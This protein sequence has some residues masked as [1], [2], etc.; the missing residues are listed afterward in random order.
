MT[1]SNRL[2]VVVVVLECYLMLCVQIASANPFDKYYF[3]SVPEYYAGYDSQCGYEPKC[4]GDQSCPNVAMFSEYEKEAFIKA[5]AELL[6]NDERAQNGNYRIGESEFDFEL[7]QTKAIKSGEDLDVRRTLTTDKFLKTLAKKLSK[8]ELRNLLD[9]K[10]CAN[11]TLSCCNGHEQISCDPY[12]PYRSY[13]GSCNNLEHP[14]WGK[15]GSALKHPF[16]PCYSD[17]VSKPARS[18]SGAPLPQNRKLMVELA[19]FLNNRN[20]KTSSSLSMFM[21]FFMEAISSDMIGR[22]N[23]R[24]HCPTQGFRGCRADGQDRSAFVSTL[25]NPLRVSPNDPYY[26]PLGVRCLNFSP[27]EKAND[28]CELKHVAERNMES[29]Y[30]DLSSMYGEVPHYD[31]SG[32]L[33]LFQCGATGP[34][35]Q[36]HPIAVQFKAIIGLFGQLHNYCVDRVSSCSQ[37]KGSVEERCRA[38]TIGVYQKL[39]YE[40]LLPLLFGEELYNLAGFD[41]EYNPYEESAI[42]QVYKNG[43]GRFPHVWIT[44]TVAYKYQGRTQWRPLNEYF[45]DHELFECTATLEGV[46]ETPIETNRL[47]DEIMHKFYTTNGERGSCLP[48]IDLA[49]NRDSGLCPLVTYKHFIEQIAG[50]E[51]KCYST[52]DDLRDM[53]SP[54]LVNFF[55]HHYEHP[56]DIDVLFSGLDQRA[57]PGAHMPKLVSQ[58]TCLEFKRLK[59]TDRF[60]YKWNPNLGEGAMHLIEILD[61]TALLALFTDAVEVPLEPFMVDGPKVGA[62]D[63]RQYLES[64]N[65]LF[66]EV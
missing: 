41:C 66:C 59:C 24:A 28:R 25:S 32:K 55:A 19:D 47:V 49:R 1:S 15:R 11:R 65:Y 9:G 34:V 52:F 45:H 54:E 58:S 43:P 20:S 61:F 3:S 8:C 51:S 31:A 63:V 6:S 53:F 48:C 57:Y 46:L 37:S 60:F 42:S 2:A 14:S 23:K 36:L 17:V 35:E 29:S 22:A 16:A 18:K 44:E 13:D 56:G 40:Q 10:C 26:G 7:F 30:L 38:L 12:H 33:P 4:Y 64:V 39:I 21:V 62:S 50:E 5:V 27:Q